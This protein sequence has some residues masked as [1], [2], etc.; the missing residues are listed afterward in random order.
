MPAESNA[1]ELSAVFARCLDELLSGSP[2]D[3]CLQHSGAHQQEIRPLLMAVQAARLAD[4]VPSPS[5]EKARRS[6]IEFL[7]ASVRE[8]IIN[9]TLG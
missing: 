7:A 6:K 8:G 1:E 5:P 3:V 2:V 9:N 4:A